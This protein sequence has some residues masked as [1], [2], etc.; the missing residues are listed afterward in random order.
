M[1]NPKIKFKVLT[2]NNIAEEGLNRF[3]KPRYT[4]DSEMSSPD[5]ILLRSYKM[6]DISLPDSLL[7]VARAGAGVNNIPV[8]K[9]SG[10][11][12]PVFNAPGA[13]A[14]AVKELVIGAMLMSARNLS[15]AWDYVR[16]LDGDKE[17]ISREVELGKKQYVGF[18]LPSRTLGVIGLGAIGVEVANAGLNLGMRV[19]GY[20]PKITV[21]RAWQLSSGVQQAA[22]LDEL[23]RHCDIVTTHV[24][25]NEATRG[26]VN[27]GRLELLPK[28]SIV[29]N[30]SRDGVID[31]EALVKLLDQGTIRNYMCDFPSPDLKDHPK[32]ICFPH[33]GAS[34]A[35]AERNCAVMVVD[36]LRDFLEN[37]NVSRSVNMPEAKLSRTRPHRLSIANANVP[38]MVGQVST[39]LAE[40]GINIADMLN[41]SREDLAYTLLDLDEPI[42]D[43]TLSRISSIDGILRVRVLPRLDT[44]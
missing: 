21:Q 17:A 32:I 44:V 41:V 28:G 6:H 12:V 16:K 39:A 15:D 26:M 9:L 36:N 29:L 42:N 33:L 18:E 30:F 31:N 4:F 5:A 35:E 1:D 38:S 10:L 2:L 43:V 37:G 23:F 13:N 22:N 20:D 3:P 34:T 19:I 8:D 25:L 40:Q 24:P 27:K 14:N 11:G 7:A